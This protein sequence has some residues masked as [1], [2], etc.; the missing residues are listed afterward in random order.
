[1]VTEQRTT[2]TSN[3]KNLPPN[4]GWIWQYRMR[5]LNNKR[6]FGVT[7]CSFMPLKVQCGVV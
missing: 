7:C 1:M 5:K 6:E 2:D 3:Q 4:D